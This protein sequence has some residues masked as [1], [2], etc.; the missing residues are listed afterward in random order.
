[1]DQSC[2]L[3]RKLD[4]QASEAIG[5]C[6][7][8]CVLHPYEGFMLNIRHLGIA[9]LVLVAFASVASAQTPAQRSERDSLW[10]GTLIGLGVAPR[11]LVDSRFAA[12]AEILQLRSERL[13]SVGR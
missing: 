11:P 7:R 1:M 2:G 12:S 9:A 5:N 4:N 3:W 6:P 13:P 10:N 8:A